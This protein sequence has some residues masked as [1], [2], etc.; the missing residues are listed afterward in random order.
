MRWIQ[1][2]RKK[3]EGKEIISD[4]VREL[5]DRI[6][7][8]I[9]QMVKDQQLDIENL[10]QQMQIVGEAI[11]EFG[12]RVA[13][14][15]K[16]YV[17]TLAQD[18]D[19]TIK[20]PHMKINIDPLAFRYWASQYYICKQQFNPPSRFSPLPYFLLCRSIELSIKS[21]LLSSGNTKETVKRL[22]SHD[23][24]RA[25][26]ALYEDSRILREEELKEL[27]FANEIYRKKG[28]EYLIPKDVLSGYNEHP[29]LE[30]LDGIAK[31]LLGDFLDY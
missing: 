9:N 28:F 16:P 23:I 14:V 6:V 18:L 4:E 5:A 10:N 2:W 27:E 29:N 7:R 21:L 30:I 31:K 19:I 15:L 20:V 25:Y 3:M 12:E 11:E 22:Y 13:D 1:Y 26:N 8:N 24:I 17:E